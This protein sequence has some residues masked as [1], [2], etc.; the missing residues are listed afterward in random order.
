MGPINYQVDIQSPF[1]ALVGGLKVG[2]TL[3]E[4]QAKAEQQR[5]AQE[6]QRVFRERTQALMSDPNP[7]AKTYMELASMLPP[8]Q[9]E[10]VRKN[11]EVLN[12]DQQTQEMRF[13]GQVMSALGADPEIAKKLL[14]ERA[15]AERNAGREDKAKMYETY[16]QMAEVNPKM[17]R[18]TIGTAFAALPNAKDFFDVV[19]KFMP[20]EEGEQFEI[21]SAEKAK[22]LGLPSGT[23]Q[24]DKKTGKIS[25]L[26]SGGVTVNMPS[27]I[28][29]GDIPKD[30]KLVYDENGRP[31]HMEVIPGSKTAREI[32]KEGAAGA[33]KAEGQITTATVVLEEIGKLKSAIK[34]QK[35]LNPV[36][37]ITGAVATGVPSSARKDAEAM[38]RSIRAN[39]GFDRLAQ[40]RAESPTGGALGNITEQELAYLQSTMGEV[41]LDQSDKAVLANLTR[42]EKIYK[43]IMRKA[44]AY[45]NADKYGYG[46]AGATPASANSVTVGGKTYSRPANFTDQQWAD[47]KRAVGAQ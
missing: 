41:S 13:V 30:Y 11:W 44:A 35:A 15:T 26:G 34:N 2:T 17:V 46:K 9:A 37:G 28:A 27:N 7:T 43:E 16:V 42:L 20:N 25:A 32:E 5:A 10:S 36:T 19:S 31:S 18:N 8:E 3:A 21:V 6:Q 45:P 23:F 33:A 40:M 29:V 4:I 1:E 12:K 47:Y 24:R 39:L 22:E 14:K 38:V